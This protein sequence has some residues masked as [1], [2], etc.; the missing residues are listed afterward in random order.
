M[1]IL[2]SIKS[3]EGLYRTPVKIW[4]VMGCFEKEKY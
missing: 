2:Y 4:N 3:E 1:Y